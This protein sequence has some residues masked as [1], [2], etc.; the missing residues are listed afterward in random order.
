VET[1][2]RET[3]RALKIVLQAGR[4]VMYQANI[5]ENSSTI[6]GDVKAIFGVSPEEYANTYQDFLS[7]VH[8]D[9]RDIVG[10][11]GMRQDEPRFMHVF[12]VIWPNGSV[13]W[14]QSAGQVTFDNAGKPIA[15]VGA[16]SNITERKRAEDALQAHADEA[17]KKSEQRLLT[18][19]NS[20]PVCLFALD[21]SLT[22]TLAEG[23]GLQAL[24]RSDSI[25]G[26]KIDELYADV[27]EFVDAAQRCLAGETFSTILTIDNVILAARLSPIAADDGWPNGVICV[28]TDITERQQAAQALT[29]A[30]KMETIGQLAAGIAHEINTPTQYI[31]D[32]TRFLQV[33]FRTLS[34][35]VLAHVGEAG[36]ANAT[37]FGSDEITYLLAEI[38]LAIEQTLE[39]TER[40]RK[41]V[42]AF[43]TFAHPGSETKTYFSLKTGIENAITVTQNEWKYT[44]DL[45]TDFDPDIPTLLC[46][47]DDLTQVFLNVIVNAAHAVADA[48]N[49]GLRERG[50]ITI[51]TRKEGD[52]AEIRIADTG[53]GIPAGI[54]SKVFDLFFTT[55]EPGRGT[56]QGL[57]HAH[58]VVVDKHGGSIRF[59]TKEGAGTTFIIRLPICPAP[60]DDEVS[61]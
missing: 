39:G 18:V 13:H 5:K 26:R 14:L 55:K 32:N 45:L 56:G 47:A 12:R 59:E 42:R 33:A 20:A 10:F 44:A 37:G 4:M 9:D 1:S 11:R 40:V 60:V 49:L 57:A 16:T 58:S 21:T 29:R 36:G 3:D 22:F 53:T 38:P 34:R 30:Q 15:V 46:L 43:K 51:T 31:G 17:L 61:Q 50:T 52:E 24:A 54:Q 41:I 48:V 27:P 2:L 8:P 23:Q 6:T 19:I 28:T 25:V 7:R 35:I